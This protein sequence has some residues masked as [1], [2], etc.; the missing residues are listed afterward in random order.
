MQ[1]I[2]HMHENYNDSYSSNFLYANQIF[3]SASVIAIIFIGF[4]SACSNSFKK[5]K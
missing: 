5:T 1:S 3:F 2:A 4:L